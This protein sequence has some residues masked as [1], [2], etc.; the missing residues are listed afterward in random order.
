MK[1]NTA[2]WRVV[3]YIAAMVVL[4]VPLSYISR[5]ATTEDRGGWLAQLRVKHHLSQAELGEI[6]PAGASMNLATLGMRGVAANVLWGRALHYKKTE[7]FTNLKATLNQIVKLQPNFISVWRFQS[8]ELAYNVAAEFDDYR[9]RYHWVKKGV[10]FLLKGV[11][12]NRDEPLLVW[13]IGWFFAHKLGR[14][15]DRLQFRRLYRQDDD[16]HKTLPIDIERT[17]GADNYPDNWLTAWQWYRMAQQIVDTKNVPIR[18]KNPVIFH[19]DPAMALIYYAMAI[20]QD[21]YL[22]E[23]GQE[24]WRRAGEAWKQ[25][26]DRN[27]LARGGYQVRLNDREKYLQEAEKLNGRL[28]ELAPGV[29]QQLGA[30]RRAQLSEEERQA[31]DTPLEQRSLEQMDLMSTVVE[32]IRVLHRQIAE[33]SPERN[34]SQAMDT[35]KKALVA[36]AIATMI[37]SLRDQVNFD[38]WRTRCEAE[39]EDITLQ[40]RKLMQEADESYEEAK[41]ETAQRAYEQAWDAWATIYEKYPILMDDP[42]AE[43][44]AETID[45]RYRD[46]LDKL[47]ETFPPAGFKLHRL[48]EFYDISYAAPLDQTATESTHED[49]EEAAAVEGDAPGVEHE[50]D[51]TTATDAAEDEPQPVESAEPDSA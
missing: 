48:L 31:L 37:G 27:I 34:R 35:A 47:D 51:S 23:K 24:A 7:D 19:S 26:G 14:A 12:Y 40:A 9:H 15:D 2:F 32:K 33:Q 44:V 13:D 8:W 3:T 43:G 4:L 41:L 30:Q 39:Q 46:L 20:E 22:D 5:P 36:Q 25:Y 17:R 21:G 50:K 16:F 29:R 10:D 49:G 18:G 38:Y 42:T 1:G 28:D 11:R 45:Q 6:D